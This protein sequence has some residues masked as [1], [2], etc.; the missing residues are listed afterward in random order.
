V[1]EL[2]AGQDLPLPHSRITIGIGW[3][4]DPT[5]GAIAS[6]RPDVDLDASV[7]EFSG[8]RL[9]DLAFYNNLSTRDGAVTHLGD[10][11]TGRGEGDDEAV[12]VDLARV[13]GPVDTLF[14]VVTSYQGHSLTWVDG[15][16]V[17]IRD[18]DGQAFARFTLTAGP[19]EPGLLMARLRRDAEGGSWTLQAVGAGLRARTAV[20]AA[21]LLPAYA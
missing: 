8:G 11:T 19:D 20:D 7:A 2:T 1:I 10:N 16:Y 14:V 12:A 4:K 21:A 3:D 13:H 6:G 17:R 15:A 18:E 5:A 9:F